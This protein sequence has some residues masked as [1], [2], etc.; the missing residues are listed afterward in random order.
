MVAKPACV[1]MANCSRGRNE[2]LGGKASTWEETSPF[3]TVYNWPGEGW[4]WEVMKWIGTMQTWYGD[5]ATKFNVASTGDG[6][7]SFCSKCQNRWDQVLQLNIL[8]P[9]SVIK[10]VRVVT[11]FIPVLYSSVRGDFFHSRLWTC[12]KK[13][14]SSRINYSR[15][16]HF[17]TDSLMVR[18]WARAKCWACW[19]V[20][21]ILTDGG[22]YRL[23]WYVYW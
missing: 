22:I 21:G 15:K 4:V 16:L 10:A 11:S 23:N 9:I 14:V 7:N 8:Q 5:G 2:R 6:S 19:F 18:S 17:L 3:E 1:L 13:F 12:Q 20:W